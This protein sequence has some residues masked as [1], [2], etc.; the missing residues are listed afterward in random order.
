MSTAL[1]IGRLARL[2]S[3]NVETIRYYQRRGLVAEPERVN[4]GYRHYPADAVNRL[5]FIKRAQALGFTLE[6]VAGLLGLSQVRACA[7]TRDVAARKVAQIDRK[8]AD[9]AAMRAA[10]ADLVIQCDANQADQ[11]EVACPIIVSLARA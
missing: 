6:E 1:T 3:V 10:L 7:E 5:R 4:G 11:R 2:A 8:L 9:L